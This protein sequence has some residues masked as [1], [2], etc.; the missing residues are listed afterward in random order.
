MKRLW[1]RQCF[2]WSANATWAVASEPWN[3][4]T[5]PEQRIPL[6]KAKINLSSKSG[7]GI[8]WVLPHYSSSATRFW[9][10]K[11]FSSRM[12]RK[13]DAFPTHYGQNTSFA[14][15]QLTWAWWVV[16]LVMLTIVNDA[17]SSSS[18]RN[19]D[20]FKH[21]SKISTYWLAWYH[22]CFLYS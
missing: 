3:S 7:V 5:A 16:E 6:H 11:I 21:L 18:Q 8:S 4:L 14:L 2:P 15:F 9:R 19:S 10:P 12:R 22:L 20:D 13:D 17:V 1:F